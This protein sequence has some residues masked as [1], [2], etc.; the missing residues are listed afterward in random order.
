MAISYASITDAGAL[1]EARTRSGIRSRKRGQE[2]ATMMQA[3]PAVH[4][5]CFQ[6]LSLKAV[7]RPHCGKAHQK[8]VYNV[9]YKSHAGAGG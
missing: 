8:Y 9:K 1:G 6:V 2:A 7:A 3:R 5:C 4:A